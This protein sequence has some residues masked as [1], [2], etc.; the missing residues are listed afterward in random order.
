[1]YV[2]AIT[3]PAG[4]QAGLDVVFVASNDFNQPNR[5]T[6]T[7]D[8]SRD[9]SGAANQFR[10]SSI[11]ARPGIQNGQDAP[12]ARPAIHS[13]GP[14]YGAFRHQIGRAADAFSF[15]V[16]NVV[17]VRDDQFAQANPPF[18]A[19][20]GPGGMAGQFVATNRVIPFLPARPAQPGPL[21][22]ERI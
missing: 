15:A 3:P 12:S 4:A 10:S 21:G 5:R 2:E 20:Q 6:A 22:Q 1:P 14:V 13:E 7:A 19:L 17:V 18:A 16:Y 9:A 11:D 8:Y